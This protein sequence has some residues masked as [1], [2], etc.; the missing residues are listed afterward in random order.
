MPALTSCIIVANAQ[1]HNPACGIV[2]SL[3]GSASGLAIQ[4]PAP[5]LNGSFCSEEPTLLHAYSRLERNRS[6]KPL[7][8]ERA[9]VICLPRSRC[10]SADV[11][12]ATL[13]VPLVAS[14]AR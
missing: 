9:G 14:N 11:E 5:N 1:P 4:T 10:A 2:G 12:C 3:R 7:V 8:S 6:G 13:D